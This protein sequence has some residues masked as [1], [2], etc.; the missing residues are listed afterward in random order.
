[1]TTDSGNPANSTLP[2]MP[3]HNRL[4]ELFQ[5]TTNS[6][7]F[8]WMLG[9]LELTAQ[10]D[11][12]KYTIEQVVIEMLIKAWYPHHYF[13]LNFGSQDMLAQ[14]IDAIRIAEDL[15]E[16]I[17]ERNLRARLQADGRQ[18]V[19]TEAI[20]AFSRYVPQRFLRPWFATELQGLSESKVNAAIIQLAAQHHG[21]LGRAAI[22][23]FE[24]PHNKAI[25]FD[26]HWLAYLR[27]H[28]RILREYTLWH[29]ARYLQKRNPNVPA[30]I[31]KLEYQPA[32]RDQ[33]AARKLWTPYL[34]AHPTTTCI[35]SG[36]SLSTF[37]IDHFLPWSFV[38]HNDIWNTIP[39]PKTV[40]S[41]KGN[42]IP[43]VTLHVP[44]FLTLQH[45]LFHHVWTAES[46]RHKEA[47][48]FQAYT[49]LFKMDEQH[50]ATLPFEAF[51]T[52]MRE[53]VEPM[54]S[55]ARSQGFGVFG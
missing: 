29:L 33:N 41:Q 40:N 10:P 27:D 38:V 49:N 47:K 11:T 51:A 7:K 48:T 19:T 13:H 17:D 22:Y 55:I 32:E 28:N 30:L 35:Y 31:H 43:Q 8:F 37:A 1:M 26:H 45:A 6:Y 44:G 21:Q 42:R 50:I 15:A 14:Q 24:G 54:I 2:W 12:Y 34:Q 5:N 23:R 9:I 20:Q 16:D 25:F 36:Q 39:I 52:R 3:G 18:R 53:Q 46:L 4:L